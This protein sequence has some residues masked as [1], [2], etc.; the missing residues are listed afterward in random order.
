MFSL[1]ISI[2]GV[3][4]TLPGLLLALVF[5]GPPAA[6][7]AQ[8]IGPAFTYQGE[9][10]LAS[11]PADGG[12]DLRFRLYDAEAG[13]SQIGP[14]VSL[15]DVQVTEG[16]FSVALD[17]GPFQFAGDRQFLEIAIRPAGTG[18]FETL[19]PRTEVTAAPYAWGAAVALADSVTTTSI[20]DGSIGGADID[21]AQVQ[22]RVTGN[23][24]V[25]QYVRAIAQNGTVTCGTDA[26]AGGTVT[27]IATGTGLTGGPITGAGTIAVA[28]GGI[29]AIQIDASQVQRRIA[30]ACAVG[31]YVRAVA[32]DGSLTCE[33]DASGWLLGGNA[34]T[35]ANDDFIG[36]TDA[37]AFVIRTAGVSSLRIE[38]SAE[39]FGGPGQPITTNMI[40]GSWVNAVR[41]GVRGATVSGGG[42]PTG[43]SDPNHLFEGP[44]LVNADYG[45][46]GGGYANQAGNGAAS[47]SSSPF[48]TVAGGQANIASGT[49]SAIGGGSRNTSS[50]G[51][52]TIGGGNN[53][54]ASETRATIGGGG[55]NA[56]T[57]S[58]S[59]IAGGRSN[60]TIGP[61]GA[62]GGGVNN[63][64]W[65]L[66][67]V[68]GGAGN[69]ARGSYSSVSGGLINCAG[70]DFS[71]AGGQRAKV[72][73]GSDPE[74][75]TCSGLTYPGGAGDQG[76]FAWADSQNSNFVSN[77]QNQFLVRAS[78]SVQF[79]HDDQVSTNN[80]FFRIRGPEGRTPLLV[81]VGGNGVLTGFNNSGVRIGHASGLI[82]PTPAENGL[83]VMGGAR[84]HDNQS[85]WD[86][87]S[88]AR[89][90]HQTQSIEGAVDTLLA[91][92]PTRFRY[93]PEF[94]AEQGAED[95]EH[96]G[97]I[98][99]ELAQVWPA[100]VQVDT[101]SPGGLLSVNL[102]EIHV[103]TTAAARELAI[104]QRALEAELIELRT[105]NAALHR[106]LDRLAAD[107]AALHSQLARRSEAP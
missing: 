85:T 45:T 71:W 48:V 3:G 28:P 59:T 61:E 56:A 69:T 9:L 15:D 30:G 87:T 86:V 24:A 81:T 76:T 97:F 6:V 63:T 46:I 40:G 106:S 34:G 5:A 25:G 50:G 90:K 95:R 29:G 103:L 16:L 73:P 18:G 72:R 8:A 80:I 79:T 92:N 44:N 83:L 94:L 13:G 7:C 98:A 42:V 26:D 53:N 84:R 74:S 99:Q 33:A 10:R 68:G 65:N 58:S 96:L 11:G 82:P 55:F 52:S 70:G 23:C 22:R 39:T 57:G 14:L 47:T 12:F 107:V 31:Q 77:G 43:D 78:G 38:P 102:S 101:A 49:M 37:Q 91:L 4:R 100:A 1:P 35:N 27:S 66:G 51:L 19:S 75:G 64:A 62:V 93:R 32:E 36:T 105:E 2:P 60:S 54:T 21:A 89:V 17:F 88:D 20:V 41:P 67:T 104:Q